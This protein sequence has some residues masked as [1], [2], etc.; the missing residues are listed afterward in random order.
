MNIHLIKLFTYYFKLYKKKF[1]HKIW[2]VFEKIDFE[3]FPKNQR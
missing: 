1:E 2:G 3:Y